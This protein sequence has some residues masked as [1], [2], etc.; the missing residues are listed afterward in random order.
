MTTSPA[1]PSRRT[2]NLSRNPDGSFTAVNS[3]GGSLTMLG[4]DANFSPVELLLAGVAGCSA[5]DVDIF[6]SRRAEPT[7]FDVE[8]SGEKRRDETGGSRMRDIEVRFHVRFPE[9]E[10][11][12]KAREILTESIINSRDRL[13]T[14]SRTVQHSTEVTYFEDE[15]AL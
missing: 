11:G 8:C 5:V 12:D 10:E 13:C 6:T 7:E 1:A 2:V 15:T 3:R 9:G 14:V 4:D